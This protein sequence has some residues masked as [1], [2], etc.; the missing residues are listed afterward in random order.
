MSSFLLVHG[1]WHGAW[2]WRRVVPELEVRGHRVL[3]LDLPGHGSDPTPLE[4]V[5][6]QDYARAVSDVIADQ[7]EAMIVVGHSMGGLVISQAA[8]LAPSHVRGLVY[9]CAYLPRH[10]QS[11][12]MLALRDQ[13]TLVVGALEIDSETGLSRI[14]TDLA[15]RAFYNDCQAADLRWATEQLGCE[16]LHAFEATV[17]LSDA[18]FGR[19]PRAYIHCERDAV[20][21]P[22][23]QR[24]ME[25]A[26]PCQ[27][28][29]SMQTGHSPFLSAHE[30]LA[31]HL[32]SIA[33]RLS[34]EV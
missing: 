21:G 19:I 6:L 3:A 13:Q 10:G 32:E 14:P 28:T 33:Q 5:T 2:C 12:G 1:A 23:L 31:L 26:S 27:V 11:L 29:I 15:R 4:S 30:E 9:L 16:P 24:E 18:R 22:V 8:E 34:T 20:I 7:S 25:A 17:S